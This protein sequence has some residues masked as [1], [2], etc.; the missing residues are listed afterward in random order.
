MFTT[1]ET[2]HRVRGLTDVQTQLTKAFLKGAMYNWLKY[3]HDDENP[4]FA[5][6]DLVGGD[7]SDTP[8][9]DVWLK[10]NNQGKNNDEAFTQA[11]IDVGWLLKAVLAEDTERK[12][13]VTKSGLTNGYRFVGYVKPERDYF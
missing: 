7:W 8:L 6:R 2:I 4:V 3:H 12:F 11:A 9:H 10:H 5:V 13:E 1:D